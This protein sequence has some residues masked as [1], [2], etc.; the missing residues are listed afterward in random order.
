GRLGNYAVALIS[1]TLTIAQA[2][3][4]VTAHDA[5]RPYGAANP[6]FTGTLSGLKNNDAITASY[7]S[8]ATATTPVGSYA[9]APTLADPTGA[10]GNYAITQAAGTLTITQAPLTV[11]ANDKSMTYGGAVPSFDAS[12]NGLVNGETGRVVHSLTCGA[13]DGNNVPVS[14]RTT[15]GKYAIT[16]GGGSAANYSIGYVSGVLTINRAPLTITANDQTTPYGTVPRVTWTGSGFVNGESAATLATAPNSA[17]I[18]GATVN[19]APVSATTVPG[20]Y[21][22]AT[23]CLNAV[24]PNYSITYANG[25]LTVNPLLSLD[26]RGLP[27]TV[28]HMATLD[29]ITVTLPR[30]NVE[31]PY[32]S[33]HRYN[34]PTTVTD[35][36]GAIY[37]TAGTGYSGTV[38][39][40]ISDTATYQTM[41]QVIS[42]ALS[43]GGIDNGGQASA[44]TQQFN[45]VQ[46][47]IKA[48]A[49]AQA[50]T[51]LHSFAALVRAQSGKHLTPATAQA[52]LAAAQ[53]VYASLGGTG[54]V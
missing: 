9:I 12:Y 34:F 50:L 6:A 46:Q 53:L 18:C 28:P 7:G 16:C 26:E 2:P 44:L 24:D 1:G 48:G 4:T 20:R 47:D 54:T 3:L 51:D 36:S 5:A 49:T 32:G 25:T 29:G 43:S 13:V 37:I 31:I 17:P 11:T 19:N 23:S 41:A 30:T 21:P 40:N 15:A 33:N 35:A 27:G 8:T 42:A 39:A 10:L 38:T 22:S 14:S 52:L 45:V